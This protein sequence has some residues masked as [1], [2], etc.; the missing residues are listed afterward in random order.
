MSD[1]SPSWWPQVARTVACM[2]QYTG[3][4]LDHAT[5][6]HDD[7]RLRLAFDTADRADLWERSGSGR[8]LDAAL[9]HHGI[10]VHVETEHR[11]ATPG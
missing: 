8:V 5:P 7:G 2:R 9:R 10:D 11:H 6:R 1:A 3:Q 4:L